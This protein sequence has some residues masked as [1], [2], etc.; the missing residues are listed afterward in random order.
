MD[1]HAIFKNLVNSGLTDQQSEAIVSIIR[2]SR[3][4][5][6]TNDTLEATFER[7]TRIIILA[8]AGIAAAMNGILFALLRFS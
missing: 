4:A 3:S 5:P 7:Q 2:D 6:L 8:T 1:T